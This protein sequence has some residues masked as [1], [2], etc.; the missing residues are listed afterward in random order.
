MFHHEAEVSLDPLR[1]PDAEMYPIATKLK[2]GESQMS[3]LLIVLLVLLVLGGG[4]WGYSR[5]RR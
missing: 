2:K 3:T 1:C 4:G 5:S